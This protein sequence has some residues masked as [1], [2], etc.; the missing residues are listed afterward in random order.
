MGGGNYPGGVNGA[1]AAKG[2]LALRVQV[3]YVLSNLTA[4]DDTASAV[5]LVALNRVG[6]GVESGAVDLLAADVCAVHKLLSQDTG[7]VRCRH[8]GAAPVDVVVLAVGAV[9]AVNTQREDIGTRGRDGNGLAVVRVRCAGAVLGAV[10]HRDDALAIGRSKL[11]GINPG[12]AGGCDHDSAL[13]EREIDGLL[14]GVGACSNAAQGQVDNLCGMLI[15]GNAVDVTARRPHDGV[16]D[17]RGLTTASTEHAN[18]LDGGQVRDTRNTLAVLAAC[19][20]DAGNVRAV[21]G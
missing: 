14:V 8:G 3:A 13:R 20:D 9:D 15:I 19:G 16:G 7:H 10:T 12:V 17:V 11:R 5:A 6:H 2:H 4:T 18:R 21:P 1:R